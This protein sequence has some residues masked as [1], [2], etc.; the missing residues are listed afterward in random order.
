M[1]AGRT[2]MGGGP[3]PLPPGLAGLHNELASVRQDID[4]HI[5]EINAHQV[6]IPTPPQ[7]CHAAALT[8][9]FRQEQHARLDAEILAVQQEIDHAN[10]R[11]PRKATGAFGAI[12]GDDS[13]V[14]Q[15]HGGSVQTSL[16]SVPERGGYGRARKAT[17][18]GKLSAPNIV[19]VLT[20]CRQNQR[21]AFH[22]SHCKPWRC[23]F[24]RWRRLARA[25]A[26]IP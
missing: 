19:S 20:K 13:M 4:F 24:C 17:G 21:A 7:Y 26:S 22:T 8:P 9:S 11:R 10:G 14:E 3:A 18:A 1:P 12:A 25:E 15:H 6:T 2:N 16:S 23:L 5:D